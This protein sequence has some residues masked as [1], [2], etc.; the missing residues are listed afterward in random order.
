MLERLREV[1]LQA[2]I[3]KCEFHVQEAK[4]LGLIISIKGIQMDPQKVNTILDWVQLTSL[5]H[6]R[7][8]FGFYNF[9]QCFIRDFSKL[10]KVFTSFTKKDTIFD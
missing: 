5:H 1:W 7:L 8:F 9:Y 2:D 10:A 6:V 3:D 4:F